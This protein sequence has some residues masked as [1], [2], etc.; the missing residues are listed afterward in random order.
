MSARVFP[1]AVG[2]RVR[3]LETD[4]T[5]QAGEHIRQSIGRVGVVIAVEDHSDIVNI[6]GYDALY[7]VHVRP[8]V[9][10]P[11]IEADLQLV[12]RRARITTITPVT[13]GGV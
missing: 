8:F 7:E 10:M 3:V 6:V 1:I 4:Y 11:L 5:R 12:E 9:P 2:D 13:T